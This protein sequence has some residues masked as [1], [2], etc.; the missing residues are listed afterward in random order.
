MRAKNVC[1]QPLHRLGF[2]IRF[3]VVT[4]KMQ[5]T[6]HGEMR[7]MMRERL[8][9]ALGFARRRLERDHDIAEMRRL[10]AAGRRLRGKR[11]HIGRLVEA[12]P[13]FIERADRRIVG[14]NDRDLAGLASHACALRQSPAGSSSSASGCFF[15]RSESITTSMARSTALSLALRCAAFILR[16]PLASARA[17]GVIGRDNARHQFMAD[18]VFARRTRPV[19]CLRHR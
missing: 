10:G 3:M 6:M 7:E 14:E 4:E 11:E 16:L 17:G 15:Q 1:F 18:D 5:I 2:A 12:A 19:R 13:S 8:F 9:V